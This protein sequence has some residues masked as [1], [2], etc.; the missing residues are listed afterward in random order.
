MI[1]RLIDLDGSTS[2]SLPGSCRECGWWQGHDG[3]WPSRDQAR[4]WRR[5]A[6]SLA[7]HWGKLA[8]ADGRLLGA[9]QFGPPRLFPRSQGL[10][11]GP[12][13]PDALLVTCGVAVAGDDATLKSL[14]MALASDLEDSGTAAVEAFGSY[15]R[16]AGCR[17]LPADLLER[18]GFVPA[19]RGSDSC[20]MRLELGGTVRLRPRRLKSH[21]GILERIKRPAASPVPATLCRRAPAPRSAPAA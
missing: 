6:E 11:A 2:D 17:F 4:E 15:Q 7:G 21:L 14:L 1:F 16:E 18:C 9:I 12:P 8:L 19:R 20:L 10:P 13:S 3:G 5:H